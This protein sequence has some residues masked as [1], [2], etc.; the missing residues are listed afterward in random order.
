MGIPPFACIRLASAPIR[1]LEG[2]QCAW[3]ACPFYQQKW[4]G[5]RRFPRLAPLALL[6]LRQRRQLMPACAASFWANVGMFST[7]ASCSAWDMGT[8]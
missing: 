8:A 7:S 5:A 4:Q 6:R 2:L 3:E 1:Q